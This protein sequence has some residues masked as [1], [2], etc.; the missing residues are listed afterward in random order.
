M[1]SFAIFMQMNT[2]AIFYLNAAYH[3]NYEKML[4]ITFDVF[5]DNQLKC[6]SN[7]VSK[8]KGRTFTCKL[9]TAS[10]II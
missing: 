4:Y 3:Q 7:W 8:S 6:N 5:N 1:V 2:V 9:H 10:S